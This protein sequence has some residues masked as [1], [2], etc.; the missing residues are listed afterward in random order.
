VSVA[1][2]DE[3]RRAGPYGTGTPRDLQGAGGHGGDTPD[4][5]DNAPIFF[6]EKLDSESYRLPPVKVSMSR[7][8]ADE[9]LAFRA[10]MTMPYVPLR[11]RA[12]GVPEMVAVP[13]PLLT[14]VRPLGSFRPTWEI[15]GTGTP[16]VVMVKENGVPTTALAVLKLVMVGEGLFKALN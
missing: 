2:H 10:L 6:L 1:G 3:F 13:S 9:F 12:S 16:V 4:Q 8:F 5:R 15:V 14:K 11:S 7:C